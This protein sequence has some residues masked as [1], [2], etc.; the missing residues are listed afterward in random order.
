MN[1]NQIYKKTLGINPKE[2]INSFHSIH[3]MAWE[4]VLLLAFYGRQQYFMGAESRDFHQRVKLIHA[5]T[6]TPELMGRVLVKL[7]E[8]VGS[9]EII[10][11]LL[12]G[13]EESGLLAK[14]KTLLRKIEESNIA[15][16]RCD[17][18]YIYSYY[19]LYKILNNPIDIFQSLLYITNIDNNF[20]S[21]IASYLES[22]LSQKMLLSRFNHQSLKTSLTFDELIKYIEENEVKI[23]KEEFSSFVKSGIANRLGEHL[24]RVFN[25]LSYQNLTEKKNHKAE[26]IFSEMCSLSNNKD[27]F[28]LSFDK[29]ALEHLVGLGQIDGIVEGVKSEII[30][31]VKKGVS[32]RVFGVEDET[33]YSKAFDDLS[34]WYSTSNTGI[35]RKLEQV[36]RLIASV[37]EFDIR[38]ELGFCSRDIGFISLGEINHRLSSQDN[39]RVSTGF[40]NHCL[41]NNGSP[42]DFNEAS[43]IRKSVGKFLKIPEEN[44]LINKDEGEFGLLPNLL[45]ASWADQE[46]QPM[47]ERFKKLPR[48]LKGK[49]IDSVEQYITKQ[50]RVSRDEASPYPINSLFPLPLWVVHEFRDIEFDS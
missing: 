26:S 41:F 47:I 9:N 13:A 48:Y 14:E 31:A 38:N 18:K 3:K 19:S 43:F 29:K 10:K 22:Y 15:F 50:L 8:G 17:K 12:D 40:I 25:G 16:S 11:M 35:V 4:Q 6:Y 49:K 1:K 2:L 27:D 33:D 46:L 20:D 28:T 24:Q 44:N 32:N 37:I 45:M 23:N 5:A 21:I 30:K 39:Y 7:Q 34:L 42:Y 36:P